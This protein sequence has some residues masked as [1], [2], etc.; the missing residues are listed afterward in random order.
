MTRESDSYGQLF[1]FNIG[2]AQFVIMY[3]LLTFL[4]LSNLQMKLLMKMLENMTLQRSV[5]RARCQSKLKG[6]VLQSDN[7]AVYF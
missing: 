3:S 1:V 6:G 2:I 7:N 4:L 5:G